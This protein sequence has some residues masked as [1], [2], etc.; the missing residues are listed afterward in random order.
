MTKATAPKKVADAV[1]AEEII[2]NTSK[3]ADSTREFVKRSAASAKERS[4]SIYDNSTKLNSGLEK[5]L[6]RAVTGYVGFLGNLAEAAHANV[7]HVLT[8]TEKLAAAKTLSEAAQI[9]ADF[10]RENTSANVE[11]VRDAVNST[12]EVVMEGVEAVRE[13]ASKAWPYGKKAA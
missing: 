3:I 12:R 7:T 9:Q 10:V 2:S 6:N 1:N 11:R 4:D 13:N 8:T 5:A